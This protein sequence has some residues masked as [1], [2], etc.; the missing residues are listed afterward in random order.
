MDLGSV[1]VWPSRILTTRCR[2]DSQRAR[3]VDSDLYH[4]TLLLEG[5][6]A[7]Q[8]AG[9]TNTFGPL[10][11]HMVDGSEPYDLWPAVRGEMS[12]EAEPCA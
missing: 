9:V 12:W 11:L 4:L 7:T 1:K 8:H 6:P 3:Q 2:L 10:D 5:G